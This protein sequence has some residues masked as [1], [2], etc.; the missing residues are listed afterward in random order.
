MSMSKSKMEYFLEYFGENIPGIF[1]NI[2][3]LILYV[4]QKVRSHLRWNI[5]FDAFH[6]IPHPPYRGG[7]WNIFELE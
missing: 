6:N 3:S 7:I 1:W 2:V 4:K 5:F